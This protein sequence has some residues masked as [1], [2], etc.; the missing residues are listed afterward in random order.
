MIVNFLMGGKLGDFLHS[1]FA[2]KQICQHKNA[3]ANVYMYDIGW[4]FGIENTCDELKPILE[5]QDYI[6][7]LNVLESEKYHLEPIQ[8]QAQNTP[9]TIFDE[10]LLQEGYIDLGRYIASPWLWKECWSDLYSKTFDFSISGDYQWIK[11]DKI[12]PK[13]EN[14]IL[15]QRKANIKR[16]PKF[17]YREIIDNYGKENILFISSSDTDYEEFP[18][19]DEIPFYKLKTLDEWFTAMNS[20]SMVIANLSAPAVMSHALDKVRI[21]ELDET[22]DQFHCIGEEKYSQN[23]KWFVNEINNNLK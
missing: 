4:E 5:Q 1:M 11:Y 3:K 19:K 12:N 18:Y 7:S 6:N 8:N 20:A 9:I 10:K 16:N 23:V 21:I 2:V 22:P 13:I 17:P 14:K 15:I